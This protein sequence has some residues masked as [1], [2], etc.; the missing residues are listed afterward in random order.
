MRRRVRKETKPNSSPTCSPEKVSERGV[1]ERFQPSRQPEKAHPTLSWVRRLLSGIWFSHLGQVSIPFLSPVQRDSAISAP[2]APVVSPP[3][4]PLLHSS[5][6]V[7]L[8]MSDALKQPEFPTFIANMAVAITEAAARLKNEA[9]PLP[10]CT[11]DV[12]T[13]LL[14]CDV[15][16]PSSR[17][18]KAI[19]PFGLS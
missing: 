9:V 7:P 5:F 12:S 16:S 10:S 19:S 15:S 6:N 2:P 8:S 1:L 4:L 11:S 14:Y 17:T 13:S 3:S 18:S